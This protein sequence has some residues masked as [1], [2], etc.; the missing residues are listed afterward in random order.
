MISIEYSDAVVLSG[1]GG[2]RIIRFWRARKNVEPYFKYVN[3]YLY[4]VHP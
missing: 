4:P 3:E 1:V 2:H